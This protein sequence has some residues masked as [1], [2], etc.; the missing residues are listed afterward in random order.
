MRDALAAGLDAC[1][2]AFDR[3]FG[4]AGNPWRHLGGLAFLLFIVTAG[5]GIVVY[6]A[7]DTSVGG[8]YRSVAAMANGPPA[9]LAL[10]RGV[11][12]YASDA[13]VL[14]MVAHLAREWLRGHAT[15]VR[16]FSWLTGVPLVAL[17]Y[18]SGIGGY[19]L[20]FDRVAQLSLTATTEWLDALPL[21]GEPLARNFAPPANVPDRLLSLLVFLHIGIPLALLAFIGVHLTRLTRPKSFPPL[22]IGAATCAALVALALV[23]PAR[24]LAPADFASE[25]MTLAFDWPYLFVHALQY[26]TSPQALW[27]VVGAATLALTLM[28]WATRTRPPPAA[29]VDLTNC[30]GCGRCFADCPYAAI[31]LVA[32]SDGRRLPRQAEVDSSRCAAC[33]I[34]AGACPSSTPFRSTSE[35]ATGIDLPQAP[36]RVLRATLDRAL[37]TIAARPAIVVFG[38]A[39]GVEVAPARGA[40]TVPIELVCAAMLPPSFVEYALRAG[41]DGVLVAGCREGDCAYRLGH[42]LLRARFAGVREPRL[43]ARVSRA[44][45][46]TFWGARSDARGLAPALAAF[47]RDL[48]KLPRGADASLPPKRRET[49]DA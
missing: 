30:N 19:W 16:W 32:R 46:R 33:G 31:T 34:C 38:C 24:L 43:R 36:I 7:Y 37:E 5:T 48:A 26:R 39:S 49:I 9:G 13:L 22:A 35:L 44:R 28:P 29:K 3:A 21:F 27:L 1:E 2:G 4:Q 10:A 17:A 12:R 47:R 45:V 8:A 42:D 41:A 20:P 14:T 40:A 18:A 6:A 23:R 25:P 15:G 11:H